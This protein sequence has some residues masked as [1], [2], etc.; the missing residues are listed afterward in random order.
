MRTDLPTLQHLLRRVAS[1]GERPALI[2]LERQGR[3]EW[4]YAT[5][6]ARA[7]GVARGLPADGLQAGQPVGIY[8]ANRPEWVAIFLGI[9]AAGGVAMPL[10]HGLGAD[11]L[12]HLVEASGLTRLFTTKEHLKSVAS[13]G[14]AAS[15]PVFRMD[16]D[17]GTGKRTVCLGAVGRPC[18][19]KVRAI[20]L[21]SMP[22]CRLPCSTPRARPA[23]RRA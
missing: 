23:C 11:E 10:N 5:L 7:E 17:E 21:M 6:A 9:V 15:F 1:Q 14:S 16:V 2:A 13:L 22:T 8:G 19:A 20:S 12:R 18:R 3:R 4:S